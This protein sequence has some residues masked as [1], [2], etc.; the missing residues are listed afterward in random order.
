MSI[1]TN[2]SEL[3]RRAHQ[4]DREAFGDLYERYLDDVYRYVYY[5]VS[6]HQ[7]AEDLTE[8][9]FLKAWQNM[10]GYQVGKAPFQAW[11]Y[12]IAHNTVIDHYRTRKETLTL[13]ENVG[14]PDGNVNVE[15]QLLF[16]EQSQRLAQAITR[17]S[18]AHQHVL[19]LRFIK[20]FSTKE[21]AQIVDRSEGAVRVLQHRA[22]KAMRAFLTAEEITNV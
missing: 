8:R 6:D 22:L 20:G 11:I 15:A 2:E 4:G 13:K 5:R 21:V 17:L 3:V 14:V 1:D 18:P 19:V 7:Y 16:K 9:V 10:S 12:R